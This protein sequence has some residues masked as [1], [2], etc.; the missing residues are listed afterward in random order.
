MNDVIRVK[1]L[2]FL[3]GKINKLLDNNDFLLDDSWLKYVNDY[4]FSDFIDLEIKE[5]IQRNL[6]INSEFYYKI[7]TLKSSFDVLRYDILN[8]KAVFNKYKGILASAFDI[9]DIKLGKYNRFFNSVRG[10]DFKIP[11]LGAYIPQGF[12]TYKNYVIISAYL[13]K[14]YHKGINSCLFIIS[15]KG[16]MLK[17]VELVGC[18]NVHLGGIA[19]DYFNH[20]LWICDAKAYISCYDFNEVIDLNDN[21]ILEKR[22]TFDIG[23][24]GSRTFNASYLTYFDGKIYVG[25]FTSDKSKYGIVKSFN[26]LLDGTVDLNSILEFHVSYYVQGLSFFHKDG[27]DY[28]VTSSSWGRK[29]DSLIEVFLYTGEGRDYAS[30]GLKKNVNGLVGTQIMPCMIEQINIKV[31]GGKVLLLSLFE[32]LAFH[33]N[34]DPNNRPTSVIDYICTND[35]ITLLGNK[36][37]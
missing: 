29:N 21:F 25:T 32:S 3:L 24:I 15:N 14:N 17:K 7:I 30:R 12:I 8:K 23:N 27:N 31:I 2:Y 11:S 16:I 13:S 5:K 26:I 37:W 18:P 33:F 4:L 20:L 10:L 34:Y 6:K 9:K 35:L 36:F 1:K 19:Y 28:I 22:F